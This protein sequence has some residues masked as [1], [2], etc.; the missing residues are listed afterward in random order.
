MKRL[1]IWTMLV[2]CLAMIFSPLQAAAKS[3][4]KVMVDGH[5]VELDVP[6]TIKEGRTLV[7]VRGVFELLGLDVAW[8]Q[9]QR[10]AEIT[11]DNNLVKLTLGNQTAV[12][13]GQTAQLDVPVSM[14]DNRLLIPL[15][16]VAEQFEYGV[17]W[18]QA[19]RTVHVT[20]A[21]GVVVQDVEEFL[22]AALEADLNSYSADMKL[23]QV[24]NVDGEEFV[25]DMEM[26]M[27]V[28]MDPIGFYQY[29]AMTMEELGGESIVS[30]AY[31]TEEGYYVS[32]MGQWIKYDDDMVEEILQLSQMQ[33]DPMYQYELLLDYA[34]NVS[35]IENKDTYMMS[36]SI[37]G[38]G[39]NELLNELLGGI[40]LGIPEEEL[41]MIGLLFENFDISISTTFDK[42][43]LFPLSQQMTSELEVSIEGET[44]HL[45]QKVDGTY[46]NFNEI[47][48]I[49]IPQ[50]VI[51]SAIS[52]DD[53]I[54]QWDLEEEVY[55]EAS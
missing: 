8:N 29:M 14:V 47:E 21:P 35:V 28:V 31:L 11:G 13:N 55:D 1:V 23:W 48:K 12:V 34:E 5:V 6:A 37:T 52:F 51:D 42:E 36:F 54:G 49:T 39:F 41:E 22:K 9:Q 53:Y 50:E 10:T 2:A 40:D 19:S 45:T 44:M 24:M 17:D 15:R 30:E 32:E 3:N 18:N 43:T 4:V 25:M 27:D 46:S 20:S 26:K 38:S 7:P 16:F 33:M